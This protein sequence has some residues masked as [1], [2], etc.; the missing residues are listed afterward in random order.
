MDERKNI[1]K[2]LRL[3]LTYKKKIAII[4]LSVLMSTGLNCY[5]P[6]INKR[7]MDEGFIGKDFNILIKLS[8][9]MLL[10]NVL[11]T[12]IDLYKENLRIDIQGNIEIELKKEVF[13]HITKIKMEYLGNL[14]NTELCMNI[15]TDAASMAN[16]ADENMLFVI[17]KVFTILGGIIGLFYIS[18]HLTLIVLIFIP[19][20][21]IIITFFSKFRNKLMSKYIE[22]IQ[23]YARWFSVTIAGM[24]EIR[25]FN[26]YQQKEKEFEQKIDESIKYNKLMN[27]VNEENQAAD[28]LLVTILSTILY[29]VGAKMIFNYQLS[30]GSIFAF[31]TYSSYVTNPIS[32]IIS[33]KYYLSGILPS[34][35]RY[36]D[37]MDLAE[38]DYTKGGQYLLFGKDILFQNVTFFYNREFPLFENINLSFSRGEKIAIIGKNGVG[39]TSIIEILLRFYDKKSGNIKMDGIDI[40]MIPLRD[41]RMLFSIVSQEIYLFNDSIFNN[42]CLYQDMNSNSVFQAIEDS[43]LKAFVDT[44]SMDYMVGENGSRLSGG[45]KQKVALARALLSDSPIIVFDEA[46]SNMD[47][48]SENQINNLLTTRL[49]EKIVIIISHRTDILDVVDKIYL[50]KDGGVVQTK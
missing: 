29:I 31:I 13:R 19:F 24:K 39:K 30:I 8:L 44:H 20:K 4:I 15:N 28:S 25:V 7:I 16:I 26:V 34:A 32:A 37:F 36:Y 46:T 12:L 1:K 17:S 35:K 14:N 3:L 38:E 40:E 43:G 18:W 27:F 2:L 22:S 5:I 45:Q 11:M 41:Y 9:L 50:L 47:T 48:H 49:S 42:I 6:I 21:Y 10:F 33:I 23:S